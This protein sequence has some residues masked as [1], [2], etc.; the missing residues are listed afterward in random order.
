MDML[1][2]GASLMA[3]RSVLAG[4]KDP[5]RLKK[6][7]KHLWRRKNHHPKKQ[8]QKLRW[9]ERRIDDHNL[10]K[11]MMAS[12]APRPVIKAPARSQILDTVIS[13]L[14]QRLSE[15]PTKNRH[16]RNGCHGT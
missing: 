7:S 15:H 4:Q 8:R 14:A 5:A 12:R 2:R 11:V 3:G 1:D 6:T 13:G 9:Q 16:L 10:R